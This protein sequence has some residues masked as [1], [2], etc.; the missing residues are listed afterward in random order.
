MSTSDR[1]QIFM[2]IVSNHQDDLMSTGVISAGVWDEL[3]Q[4]D[5]LGSLHPT[6]VIARAVVAQILQMKDTL[7]SQTFIEYF[8]TNSTLKKTKSANEWFDLIKKECTKL[9]SGSLW[10]RDRT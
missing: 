4:P 10:M 5:S 2:E 1:I 6:T 7:V 9:Q 8:K 3:F